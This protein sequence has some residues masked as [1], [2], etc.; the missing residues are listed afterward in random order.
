MLKDVNPYELLYNEL[1]ELSHFQVLDL[2]VYILIHGEEWELKSKKFVL[3]AL[4]DK[5]V[6]FDIYIIYRIHVKE[7]K[8]VITVKDL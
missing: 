8:R 4:K 1:L 2:T 5:L 7:Q 6:G 3:R